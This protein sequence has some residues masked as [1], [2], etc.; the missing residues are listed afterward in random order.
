MAARVLSD[1]ADRV[2]IIERDDLTEE[3]R[4]RRAAGQPGACRVLRLKVALNDST[5]ALSAELPILLID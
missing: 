1:D 5:G 3:A 4:A 2:L